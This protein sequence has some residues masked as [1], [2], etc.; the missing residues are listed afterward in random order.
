MISNKGNAI[1]TIPANTRPTRK[2]GSSITDATTLDTPQAAR[3]A[4]VRIFPNTMNIN[5]LNKMVHMLF[6]LLSI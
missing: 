4:N 6:S 1:F 3:I 5:K 2:I